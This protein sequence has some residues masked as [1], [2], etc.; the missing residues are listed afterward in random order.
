MSLMREE[1]LEA[2]QA[3]ARF[4]DGNA[5][6]LKDLGARLRRAAP[7]VVLTSA[8]GSSDNA[9]AYFKYVCEI[10]TGVPCASLGASVVSVYGGHLR[11]AGS[12]CLTISQS[13]QSPDIVAVQ[14]A[15][16]AAGAISVA[17]VNV[18]D[19]PAARD[20]DICLCLNAGAERSVAATKS[21]IASCAAAAAIVAQWSGDPALQRAVAGL[22]E[23]LERA[24][25][26]DWP[27]FASFA[28]EAPSLFV[29]GRGP[30]YPI[31]QETALKL[32][33]TCAIHAEAYS[34]AEVM[35]GPW[36]LMGSDF[37]VLV[38]APEDAARANTREAVAKM[39]GTGAD[40]RVVGDGLAHAPSGHALLDPVSMI[41]T[42][43]LEIEQV[44]IALGRD[45]DRPRLLRKV[46]ETL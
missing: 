22:P 9:A 2:P 45:P 41:A 23:T 10:V 25:R 19:S 15:A 35:H 13:G 46:T 24:V 38:Y 43:Y 29:L 14:Q 18:A 17:V 16:K 12:L 7:P 40:L 20:A 26:L 4:L 34:V 1:A 44:A 42:A 5:A 8:R 31:A 3:V 39:R 32:K 33:E 28:T 36:E 6:A 21:F 37:P 27:G 11:A 30:S